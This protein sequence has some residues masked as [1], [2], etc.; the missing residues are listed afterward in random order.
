MAGQGRVMH[1][2]WLYLDTLKLGPTQPIFHSRY[3]TPGKICY[4][5]VY[6]ISAAHQSMQLINQ[7][8]KKASGYFLAS[9]KASGKAPPP[10]EVGHAKDPQ[11]Q[12][13]S[14][15]VRVRVEFTNP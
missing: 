10:E 1:V 12:S 6:L 15:T 5:L 9:S 4:D 8:A 2:V 11:H 7:Y 13:C 3:F 14:R